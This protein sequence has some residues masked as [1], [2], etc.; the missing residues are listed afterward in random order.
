MLSLKRN[1]LKTLALVEEILL[2]PRWNVEEFELAKLSVLN[3]LNQQL[4]S[5]QAIAS[6]TYSTLIYGEGNILSKNI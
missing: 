2:E 4:A 3:G 1:Y 6:N 5:P